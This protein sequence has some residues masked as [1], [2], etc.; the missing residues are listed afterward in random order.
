MSEDVELDYSELIQD[1]Q[2]KAYRFLMQDVLNIVATLGDAPGEHHFFIEFQTTANG[3]SIP[4]HLKAQY[5][6]RMTIVLQHQFENLV[7]TDDQFSV[8]LWFKG[9]EANLVIPFDAVT[10]F[11]DPSAQ[12]GVSFEA[13]EEEY[14]EVD[15]SETSDPEDPDM[16]DTDNTADESEQKSD[17][18]DIVSLDAFRKK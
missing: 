6:E 18:A 13:V 9:K 7:V 1:A 14:E 16:S 15:E 17:G 4:D 8:T 5:P 12:F 10:Q 2:K 3:V 11:A